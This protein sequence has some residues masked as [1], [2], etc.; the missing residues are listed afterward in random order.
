MEGF[1]FALVEA[2]AVGLVPVCS[3]VGTISDHLVHGKN[4]FIFHPNNLN[5]FTKILFKLLNDNLFYDK[6]AVN[7]RDSS[8]KFRYS[9][10]TKIWDS[11]F[12][13]INNNG[14]TKNE[15]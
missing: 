15:D 1:P 12:N 9:E 11:W 4:G 13:Q 10:S 5:G 14:E 2:M 3:D 6:I 7:V 8:K